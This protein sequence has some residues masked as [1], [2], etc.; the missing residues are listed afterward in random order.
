M[1][2]FSLVFAQALPPKFEPSTENVPGE[3][4]DPSFAAAAVSTQR[5]DQS[6]KPCL[7]CVSV[8]QARAS[9]GVGIFKPGYHK[10]EHGPVRVVISAR[11]A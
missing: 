11:G 7:A 6:L 3:T 9:I 2:S 5:K 8:T 4:V 10:T 1:L